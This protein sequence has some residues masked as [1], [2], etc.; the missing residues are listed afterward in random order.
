MIVV[1]DASPLIGLERIQLLDLLPALDDQVIIPTAV[2]VELLP[3]S[4]EFAA[5]RPEW[6]RVRDVAGAAVRELIGPLHAGEAEAII[7]AQELRVPLIIDEKAG[8]SVARALGLQVIGTVAVVLSGKRAGL[9]PH[10][11]PVLR[12]LATTGFYLSDRVLAEARR[13]AGE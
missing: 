1:S 13:A 7:L 10:A 11:D 9:I 6:L 2:L 12:Q 5:Q 4:P 3:G 8:R